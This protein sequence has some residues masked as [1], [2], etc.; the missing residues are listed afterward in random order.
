METLRLFTPGPVPIEDHLLAIGHRQPPY[1]RTDAFS[2]YTDEILHGLKYVFQTEGKVALLTGSGTAAMEAAVLN[3]LDDKDKV[4]IINGGTFGQRWCDLCDI[5]AVSYDE[6]EVPPGGDLDL[7][8]LT[9][10][11]AKPTYTALLINAHETSTGHLYDIRAIGAIARQED[12]L[13]IV[14]AISSICADPFFM[15]EWQVDVAILSSQKAL[16]LPPGLSF[17]AMNERAMERLSRSTPKSVY[18]NIGR[19]L[20]DQQ[21]G[22]SPYTPAIGV[23]LQLHQRLL[24]LQNE[25]LAASVAKHHERA[26]FFRA[27]MK[28]L[29][30]DTLPL[31]PSNALTALLCRGF[32]AAELAQELADDHG[33][34]VAPSGGSLKATLIRISHMGAQKEA[35]IACLINALS[36]R[37]S[38][39]LTEL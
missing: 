28:G 24:D 36:K 31:R 15:D 17:V 19:Y 18:F 38:P 32:D 30:F 26:T 13:F 14:D 35:D 3:Y 20:E 23:M 5:H 9:D 11:L 4:L 37:K 27:A 1:N 12:V 29:A 25:T 2:K 16:A 6:I 8:L 7:D 21:R 22:Q 39:Q 10:R 33:L 34:F